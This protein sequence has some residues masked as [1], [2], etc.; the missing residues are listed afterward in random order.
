MCRFGGDGFILLTVVDSTDAVEEL[1]QR[2]RGIVEEPQ[3]VGDQVL[4]VSA[5]LGVATSDDPHELIEAVIRRA[6]A[7]MRAAAEARPRVQAEPQSELI[8]RLLSDDGFSVVLQPL[9]AAASGE[10]E[11]L[12]ALVRVDDQVFGRLSPVLVVGSAQRARLLDEVTEVVARRAIDAVRKV[13]ALVGRRITLLVN[14]EFAQLRPDSSLLA[15]LRELVADLDV[16]LVLE[17]S[18]R[19]FDD[20]TDEHR[21]TAEGLRDAGIGLAIDDYGAGYATY[22]LLT[23]WRWDLVKID[24]DIV[25]TDTPAGRRL[26]VH[27]TDL[28]V[29]LGFPVVAEGVEDAAQRAFA[30]ESGAWL[31]QGWAVARPLPADELLERLRAGSLF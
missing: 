8:S 22:S 16:E 29:D 20:W 28:L 5:S 1:E 23:Q 27:V 11:A 17:V 14:I 4:Q 26:L 7:A 19:A 12:E 31:L 15:T 3:A 25:A 30:G 21:A 24:R 10:L 2:V 6:E 9:V 18:E 13:E